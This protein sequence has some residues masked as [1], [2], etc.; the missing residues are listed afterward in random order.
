MWKLTISKL[1][2][3][4]KEQKQIAEYIMNLQ[5]QCYYPQ[6]YITDFSGTEMVVVIN[7]IYIRAKE[8]VKIQKILEAR[9]I[10][11]TTATIKRILETPERWDELWVHG[12]EIHYIKKLEGLEDFPYYITTRGDLIKLNLTRMKASF[13]YSITSFIHNGETFVLNRARQVIKAFTNEKEIGEDRK[14]FFVNG[15]YSDCNISNVRIQ[16]YKNKRKEK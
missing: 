2:K 4:E 14:I 8:A 16:D 15:K 7:G 13:E 1:N 3:I 5:P 10:S 6:D 12:V 11:L 9:N